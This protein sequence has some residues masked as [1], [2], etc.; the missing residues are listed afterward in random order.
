MCI[1]YFIIITSYP[2]TD[3]KDTDWTYLQE[4]MVIRKCYF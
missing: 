3:Y 2:I 4:A 1:N